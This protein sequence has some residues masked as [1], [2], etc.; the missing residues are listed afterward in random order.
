M[1]MKPI[2]ASVA[3]LALLSGALP[4]AASD[5]APVAL[6][7]NGQPVSF[8]DAVPYENNGAVFVPVRAAAE[9]LGLEVAYDADAEQVRLS[10]AGLDISLRPGSA[11]A[12]VNGQETAFAPASSI[13]SDRTYVP[14]AFFETVF[15]LKTDYRAEAK[16]ASIGNAALNPEA[17]VQE[18]AGLLRAGEYQRLSDAWFS[19][20]LKSAV[21]VEALAAGWDSIAPLAGEFVGVASVRSQPM[22]ANLLGVEAILEYERMSFRISAAIDGSQRLAG[23]LVQPVAEEAEAPESIVEEQV[24]VGQG[25]AYE[26]GGT[27]TLPANASGP[28]PA[29]VLVQGSGPSDRDETA[30]AYKPFRDIA[31]GLAQQGIAVLRYDKRTYAYAATLTPDIAA[32]MTVAEESVDDA[33]AAAKLLREDAR[34]DASRLYIIG[35]S[36]GGMLAPRID[37]EGGDF[38]G[39][40]L[41]AGSPRTLWE[42]IYDQNMALVAGMD[43]ADPAKAMNIEFI[44]AEYAK[45]KAIA[46]MS[47][48]EAK[49]TTA[50]GIPA[51][52]FK[53]MDSFDQSAYAAKVN[54]PVLVLQGEDDFQVYADKDFKAY[55]ALFG[56]R[57]EVTYKLYPGL[58]HFFVDYSGPGEGTLEEYGMPGKVSEAVIAD[59]AAWIASQE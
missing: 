41:L 36:Q 49:S 28:V 54:K 8:T 17:V 2:A 30:G 51:Y 38:A 55:K 45:A 35:H 27:L 4:A 26:L 57:E 52:Y 11:S 33:V 24:V 3:A 59:V 9:K 1:K 48:E 56:E 6:S 16:E 14:L 5:R 34:I 19:D 15:G 21:P 43:D 50:F 44:E 39:V 18:L 40:V 13:V 23:L 20:E 37:A 29:V 32:A 53:E 12:L 58:N 46:A 25:S 47:E 10:A 31:W 7:L 22:D 42:I